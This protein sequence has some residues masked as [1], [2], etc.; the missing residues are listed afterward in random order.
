MLR[1]LLACA[2]LLATMNASTQAQDSLKI[3]HIHQL[4]TAMGAAK[5]GTQIMTTIIQQYKTMA[6]GADASFWDEYEKEVKFDELVE[7]IVPIYDKNFTDDDILQLLAFY[8]SPIGRKTIEKMPGIYQE[9]FQ[10][11]MEWG[12]KVSEKV[13]ERLKEKG[14]MKTS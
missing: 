10:I 8:Q 2:L 5:I 7:M 13:M 11:G 9:S 6:P 3:K 12:K 1:K 14:Y 4:M